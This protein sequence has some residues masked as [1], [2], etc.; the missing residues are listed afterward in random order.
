LLFELSVLYEDEFLLAVDKPAGIVV[1]PAYKN[2]ENTL[3]DALQWHA[4]EWPGGARPSI[5]GRLDK[6]TSG[7][8]VVAKSAQVHAALQR[9]LAS[10]AS[11]KVYLA[12]VYGCVYP[13]R[14][15]IDA[16]LGFD[17]ADRRRIM[18][19]PGGWKSL[20]QFETLAAIDAPRAGLS[21]LRCR[22]VTGR[23]HQLRVHLASRGWPIVGDEKYGEPRWRDIDD[24]ALAALA[25]DCPR[26]ALH[27]SRIA[28]AHPT[29]GARVIVEAEIPG[30][31]DALLR[32]LLHTTP[33]A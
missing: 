19:T 22:L 16:P 25:R 7:I 28:F 17:P 5:V 23:R 6:L 12:I 24:A 27:A 33:H 14:G 10:E 9:T 26:Q 11:E 31:L 8:V 30:D 2:K 15:E 21:L 1:H 18:V 32:V 13:P 29:T 20:T 4:R 3:L